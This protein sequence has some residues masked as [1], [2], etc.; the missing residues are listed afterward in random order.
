MSSR[1]PPLPLT[2]WQRGLA[3][4]LEL[5]V[6]CLLRRVS[7]SFAALSL[8][9]AHLMTVPALHAGV[10]GS[11]LLLGLGDL[12]SQQLDLLVQGFQRRVAAL[13]DSL[14]DDGV[15]GCPFFI[16][17][18]AQGFSAGLEIGD[19]LILTEASHLPP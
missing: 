7:L 2:T 4:S 5:G 9:V 12:F 15:V 3:V 13:G 6:A 16:F 17:Q 11:L 14:L 18:P 8:R 10:G 1:C 19:T